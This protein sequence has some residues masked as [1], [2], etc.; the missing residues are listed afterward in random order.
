MDRGGEG[1]ISVLLLVRQLPVEVPFESSRRL[2]PVPFQR[3]DNGDYPTK[4]HEVRVAVV[5]P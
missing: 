2:A 4:C 3:L 5:A 1:E